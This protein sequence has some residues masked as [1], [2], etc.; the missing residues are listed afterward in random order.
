MLDFC[1]E[2]FAHVTTFFG[3]KVICVC[4]HS[5]HVCMYMYMYIHGFMEHD[6]LV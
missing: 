5:I 3:Y 6:M 4:V 2:L 1:F